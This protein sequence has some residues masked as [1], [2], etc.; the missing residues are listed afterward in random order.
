MGGRAKRCAMIVDDGT[1]KHIAVEPVG[2][3]DVSS[4]E[5][6]LAHL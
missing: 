4:A 3:I 2:E 5:S 1:V 6:I